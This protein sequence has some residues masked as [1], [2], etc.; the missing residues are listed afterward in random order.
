MH[1][2]GLLRVVGGRSDLRV[3]VRADFDFA[4]GLG[5]FDSVR[6]LCTLLHLGHEIH[7]VVSGQVMLW[8]FFIWALDIQWWKRRV[9]ENWS[10]KFVFECGPW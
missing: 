10:W 7:I 6:A 4:S 3:D 5:Q 8:S 1:N 9:I 2:H